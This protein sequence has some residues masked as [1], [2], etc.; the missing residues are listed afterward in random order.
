MSAMTVAVLG[1]VQGVGFRPFVFQIAN[2]YRINGTVQNNMDGVRIH[3]EGK[4]TDIEAFLYDLQEHPP[5]L[6]IISDVMI[7]P[8]KTVGYEEFSIIPS[9]RAG[10]S[11]LV[12][13]VDSAVCNDCLKEM[14]DTENFRFD[15]PFINCTQ[16]GPRYT[17]IRDLPYDRTFSS[18]ESFRMCP[19]CEK[20]YKDPLNRR[21]HAQPIACP[22]CGP[23]VTL[24]SQ[25]GEWIGKS[26]LN[27]TKELIKGGAIVAIKGLG[28]Y[29]LCCDA[30]NE[31]AV[32]LLR[33]K[34]RRPARPLAVMAADI[35]AVS[36]IAALTHSEW[37]MLESPEAPI[38]VLRK[39]KG[40]RLPENIAPGMSTIG[41]MLPYTP[42]H[43]LL[44][45]ESEL[46]Y[47]VMTSANPSGQ[48]IL[49]ND[50]DVFNN[51]DDIADHYLCHDRK[52]LH[53][54]DDSVVQV[55]DNQNDFMRRARGY[56]PDPINSRFNVHGI[57]GFGS[58][59]KS[60][61]A[62]GRNSQI[63]VGPHIGNLENVETIEHYKRELNHLLNWIQTPY[64]TAAV[65]LHPGYAA[66]EIL[67]GYPFT[68][69][70]E[71]QHHHAHMAA[72]MAD[73][74]LSG[75]V[76]AIILD[77][78]GYGKDGN[79]W[80]FEILHGNEV[81]F[82]R[83]A[84]LSYT[85]L[86][87]GEKAIK[88]PW[89]NAA[90]MLMSQWGEEGVAL[91]AELYPHKTTE[92]SILKT[93]IS[94]NINSPLAGTC[95]RLFDAVS[96][97]CGICEVSTYDGEA[98]VKLAEL[99]EGVMGCGGIYPF[100][101]KEG[102]GLLSYDFGIMLKRIVHEH[103]SGKAAGEI[104]LKFQETVIQALVQGMEKLKRESEFATR[105]IVLSGGSFHNR[106]LKTRLAAELSDRGFEVYSHKKLPCNDGG[107]SFGQLIVAAARRGK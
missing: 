101:I 66:R 106:Y 58:Q 16:C 37:S 67:K 6:S 22:I 53:P 34:K 7:E 96:A 91:A 23:A 76:W 107:L 1:R 71:V 14:N 49:Y 12:L 17:I 28:G 47:L 21:H 13:P 82:E 25:E 33:T 93:M 89:R 64:L 42:L 35:K 51:L 59:Q 62:L 5:R 95:G 73:N 99:A 41:V 86:P 39:K 4:E 100:E 55:V 60:T 54:V 77:G 48:P 52:I 83:M 50:E 70:L 32:A 8:A 36:K 81:E 72:C 85:P 24:Y 68:E 15:Y 46:K 88:E 3:I 63:F 98:A 43:H 9:E 84:H 2:K 69:V 87:G 45:K 11:M 97:I 102:Y 57:I 92:L 74:E 56:V 20:E 44:F 105:K 18:M 103:L 29:H 80:G 94:K 27:K 19:D 90:A 26:A 40:H 78:T 30:A 10:A 79:I 75:D 61:F 65:D 31:K 38:V 104:S